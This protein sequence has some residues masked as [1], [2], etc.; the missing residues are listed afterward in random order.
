MQMAMQQYDDFGLQDQGRLM[1]YGYGVPPPP[2]QFDMMPM[3]QFMPAPSGPPA[4]ALMPPTSTAFPEL[5][6]RS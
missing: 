4:P 3:Q 6:V 2:A 1:P 5:A